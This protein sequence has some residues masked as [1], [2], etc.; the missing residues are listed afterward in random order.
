MRIAMAK[1]LNHEKRILHLSW[2]ILGDTLDWEHYSEPQQV[3]F[4]FVK[5]MLN[6]EETLPS[7]GYLPLIFDHSIQYRLSR[8]P[9]HITIQLLH[10]LMR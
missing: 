7:E 4:L 2:K 10:F 1:S 3:S 6:K 9:W 5:H 8:S